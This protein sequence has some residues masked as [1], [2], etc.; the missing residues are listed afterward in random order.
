M[1]A[2]FEF[3]PVVK[4]DYHII[5]RERPLDIGDERGPN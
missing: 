3:Y 4:T 5:I 2:H 1:L